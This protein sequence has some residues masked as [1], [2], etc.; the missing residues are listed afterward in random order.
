MP[1]D[2]TIKFVVRT[3]AAPPVPK[4]SVVEVT[5]DS[6]EDVALFYNFSMAQ[7][8]AAWK[9]SR[10]RHRHGVEGYRTD[11]GIRPNRRPASR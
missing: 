5:S 1:K 4:F 11:A 8:Y 3:F 2:T 6:G 10:L 9:N 7:E